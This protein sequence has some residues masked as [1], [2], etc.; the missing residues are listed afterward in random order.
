MPQK[1]HVAVSQSRTRD[2]P[3]ETLSALERTTRLAASR[4]AHVLLFPEAYL[5]GYPRTCTFGSS[6]G[7][8][9]PHGHEQFLQYYR[10]AVDLGDTPVGA[11]DGWMERKLPIA[12]GKTYRGDGTR[13]FLER[14]ARETGIL[15]IVGLVERA[16]GSLYCSVVY[17]DPRQGTLGKRRKVMPVSFPLTSPIRIFIFQI[18]QRSLAGS[19]IHTWRAYRMKLTNFVKCSRLAANA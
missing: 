12:K 4:G 7:G 2:T 15:I 1:L 13:E 18:V 6:V 5:G 11:G 10:A 8:R 14:V 19:N 3:A 17:V 16:G 9:E